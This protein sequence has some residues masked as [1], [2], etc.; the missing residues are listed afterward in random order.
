MTA[1]RKKRWFRM[2]GVGCLALAV[3]VLA[4]PVWFP[5]LLRPVL[6][7]FGVAF[8]SYERIGYTRFALTQ[9][10]GEFP[11]ARFSGERVEGFLPPRWLWR[12]YASSPGEDAFLTVAGWRIDVEPGRGGRSGGGGPAAAAPL[13]PRAHG[14]GR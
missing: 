14:G 8:V 11:G 5:W 3:V 12:R 6:A 2:F 13:P 9:V 1:A 7:R 10:R 4:L